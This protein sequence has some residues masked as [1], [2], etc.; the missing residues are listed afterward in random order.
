MPDFAVRV[1]NLP[2]IDSYSQIDELAAALTIHVTNIVNKEE[3]VYES[4]KT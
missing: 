4:R 1:K 3:E 2:A